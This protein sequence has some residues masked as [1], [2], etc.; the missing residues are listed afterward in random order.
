MSALARRLLLLA[1]VLRGTAALAQELPT[2]TPVGKSSYDTVAKYL[3]PGGSVY[4]Y[5]S[6]KEWAGKL[7]T[8]VGSIEGMVLPNLGPEQAGQA[9]GV[10]R[11][12]HRFIAESGLAELGGLG[13]SSV[14]TGE[15]L[16]HNRV[17]LQR[18]S[19]GASGL[20]WEAFGG[21]NGAF[22]LLRALPANTA[23][24]VWMPCDVKPVWAW[25]QK[26]VQE[27]GSQPMSAGLAQGLQRLQAQ[28]IAV[29]AWVAALGRHAAFVLTIDADRKYAL[30]LGGG[31]GKTIE[32]PGF[33]LALLLEVRDDTIFRDID[34]R[35]A[36]N[37]EVGRTDTGSLRQRVVPSPLPPP[38]RVTVAQLADVLI[39]STSDELVGQLAG[40]RGGLTATPLF[41]KLAAGMPDQGIGFSFVSP[42][43]GAAL[44]QAMQ[45]SLAPA[46]A[47]AP[48]ASFNTLLFGKLATQA[49]YGVTV[50]T[51]DGL[52][53]LSNTNFD[54]G[55]NLITQA[56][57]A[58]VAIV[59]GML[60]PALSQARQK[61]RTV[62]D[63]SNLKQIGLGLH[64]C[65]ADNN[66]SYPDDLG[67]LMEKGYLTS[68]RVFVS[69]GARTPPPDNAE[70][71][72]AGQCDYV[73]FGKGRTEADCGT[74]DAMA[75][76]KPGLLGGAYLNVLYGDGHVRGFA[77]PPEDVKELLVKAGV[78][79]PAVVRVPVKTVTAIPLSTDRESS[80]EKV[81]GLT[82]AQTLVARHP[83]ARV[84][85]LAKSELFRTRED[86]RVS[87]L[88]EGLQGMTIVATV[89]LPLPEEDKV[90][91]AGAQT[92]DQRRE[93]DV[94]AMARMR[95][96]FTTALVNELT[97]AYAG[98]IDLV[99]STAG[100]PEQDTGDLWFWKDNIKVAI[101]NGSVYDLRQA[102]QDGRI[103]AAVT[104]NPQGVFDDRPIPADPAAAFASRFLLLTP[105][106]VAKIAAGQPGIFK[107]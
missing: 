43:L 82:L 65:S 31:G 86:P 107:P 72:R 64:Q 81:A 46:G 53:A 87:G 103:T 96:W 44:S 20:Y 67:V 17:V 36:A 37:P 73:Y 2:I 47:A 8:L 40:G 93:V 63:M 76:T 75:C 69:P 68:G 52:V 97:S 28:G 14:Q 101:A 22:D 88:K 57:M 61:A 38:I 85:I 12:I 39:L 102:I 26:A 34:A 56:A 89:M 29:D 55:Q 32:V 90:A 105:D 49:A 41:Q 83:K 100:L 70:Q 106:T 23:M 62:S 84:L 6:T 24:A 30:P 13:L 7:D 98:K 91:A 21:E 92:N 19:G 35:L 33:A 54:Y 99:I 77:A 18:G 51:P 48:G 11:I 66:G 79:T 27:S 9:Q 16:F 15:E 1:C 42:A 4:A 104:Y 78:T 59:A 3:N 94:R 50:N 5:V 80:Y 95:R 60:L 25:V 58:P 71:L 45:A 10:L 74:N